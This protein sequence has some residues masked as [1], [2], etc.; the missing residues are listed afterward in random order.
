MRLSLSILMCFLGILSPAFSQEET[1]LINSTASEAG[2]SESI[3]H[4]A[5][6][7]YEAAVD[8]GDL[9]GVVILVARNGRV[10]VHKSIGYLDKEKKIPMD[11]SS[12]FH[13]A[14]NTK[15]V[16]ATA[17]SILVEKGMFDYTDHI[18]EFLPEWDNKKSESINVQ[19][20]LTHTSG[21]NIQS[22][23]LPP[24]SLNTDLQTSASRF[25]AIGASTIPGS[26]FSYNNP[27]YNTLGALIEIHTGNSLEESLDEL[28][29]L[30]LG[31]VDTYN[32]RAEHTMD[33]KTGCTGPVYYKRNDA[34]E[35]MPGIPYTIPFARG[36]GGLVST[37]WDYAVFC[38]MILN[39]G[40][41][42]GKR[43]LN[44]NTVELMIQPKAALKDGRSY[45]YGWFI[46]DEIISHGGSDGTDAWIDLK[47]GIIG[48]VFTQT[49]NG[50]P[51]IDRFRDLIRLS[52]EP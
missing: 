7:L 28:I 52:I 1:L 23:F 2:M 13:M 20:L 39:G 22:L 15:P 9:V 25:G 4:D 33:G 44:Q 34:G 18:K 11:T 41:Y 43:I 49:P 21:L 47:Y 31:M 16:I 51:E 37:V 17:I 29:Y 45:G 12:M 27:G 26:V 42:N 32:Y 6:G 40:V 48:L 10:V 3:L 8:Q 30:P 38:Q 14:S 24:D 5:V 50:R 46:S 35:W 19:H 36:S